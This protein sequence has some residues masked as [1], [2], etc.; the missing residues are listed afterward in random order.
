MD[1]IITDQLSVNAHKGSSE[2][3]AEEVHLCSLNGFFRLGKGTFVSVWIGESVSK[4][5][6]LVPCVCVHVLCAP[7]V[8]RIPGVCPHVSS[9]RLRV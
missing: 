5:E 7:P 3:Q 2:R 1:N 4:S 8:C 6:S 9:V